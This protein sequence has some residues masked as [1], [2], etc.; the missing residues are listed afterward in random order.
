[1]AV[2][3]YADVQIPTAISTGLRLRGVKV[4]TAQEDG[5][6]RFEDSDLLTRATELRMFLYTHDDDFLKEARRRVNSGEPFSGVIFSHQTRSPTGRC[7]EDIEIIAKTLDPDSLTGQI[8][9]VP[10]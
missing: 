5:A 6:R 1:M 8:E 3:V 7:I 2:G 4:I 9:Y 10:F